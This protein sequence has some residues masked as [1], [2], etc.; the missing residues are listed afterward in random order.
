MVWQ[1]GAMGYDYS[2]EAL[3]GRTSEKPSAFG[4]LNNLAHRKAAYDMSSKI[5][6]L[7]K[8]FPT[9]FTQGTF[10][11]NIGNND[12]S[13][14]R[15]IGLKHADLNMVVLG[16]FQADASITASPNFPKTGICYE[17]LTGQ[18]LSVTNAQ[19]TMNMTKGQLLIYTDRKVDFGSGVNDVKSEIDCT[20]HP[21]VTTG[22]VWISTT[23]EVRNVNIYNVQGA[24]QLSRTNSSEIDV[25]ELSSGMY[26]M[27]IVTDDGKSIEKFVKR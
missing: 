14:G 19:M 3:G 10:E 25:T 11:L 20:I 26:L 17:L 12:W 1:F 16:N 27:E 15:R 2:I 13:N 8:M 22:K 5:I 18:E 4:W 9:A 7:R 23:S 24:L 6:S 21:S